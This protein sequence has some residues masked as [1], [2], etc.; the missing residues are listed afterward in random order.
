MNSDVKR[1]DVQVYFVGAGPG[2]PELITVKGRRCI[3]ESDLII[4]TGSLV[5]YE[6]ISWKKSSA[7]A[8]N[9]SSMTLDETHE[10]IM[11]AVKQGKLVA[12]VHT[13]DPSLYGAIREQMILLD[14]ENVS[15]EVIPGVTSALAT[16]ASARISLTVPEVTQTV[17]FTRV[18]GRTPVPARESLKNLAGHGSTI[19]VY[20]SAS[21]AMEVEEGLISG[22]YSED[23]PVV[24]G[25]RVGW[26]DEKIIKGR[27]SQLSQLAAEHGI[28]R[29]AVFLITPF[30][31]DKG[32][33]SKL[34]DPEF[35]HGFRK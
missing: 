14:K 32:G 6:I 17:I 4:Y 3:M 12:R 2:D 15:Y 8:M 21:K 31:N 18:G 24:I 1:R 25:Y 20:L 22:G 27:L 26:S 35:K 7:V 33:A 5:P 11:K 16:A 10:E 34:Y 29:Q 23:T 30:D 19:A 13:G 9:S 28:K